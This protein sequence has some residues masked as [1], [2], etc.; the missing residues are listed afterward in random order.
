MAPR[1]RARARAW[2]PVALLPGS[3]ALALQETRGQQADSHRR[4]AERVEQLLSGWDE[5]QRSAEGGRSAWDVFTELRSLGSAGASSPDAVA[6]ISEDPETGVWRK[7]RRAAAPEAP[8]GGGAAPRATAGLVAA[9]APAGEAGVQ[10][11]PTPGMSELEYERFASGILEREISMLSD[12]QKG[13]LEA[14]RNGSITKKEV[15]IVVS[16]FDEH[17]GWMDMYEGLTTSYCKGDIA[18][19]YPQRPNKCASLPNV[20]REGHTFLNHIIQNYDRLADWTVF[21]QAQAPTAGWSGREGDHRNGHIYPGASFHDYVLGG[22]PFGGDGGDNSGGRFVF[23]GHWKPPKV[24]AP[25]WE[26]IHMAFAGNYYSNVGGATARLSSTC[27]PLQGQQSDLDL[28]TPEVMLALLAFIDFLGEGH[29]RKLYSQ[30]A[31]FA[32]SR[33]KIRQRP[34]DF[35]E[36]LRSIVN[37]DVFPMSSVFLELLWYYIPGQPGKGMPCKQDPPIACPVG[38]E[39][40][41]LYHDE[42]VIGRTQLIPGVSMAECAEQCWSE[43]GAFEYNAGEQFCVH[44]DPNASTTDAQSGLW[45][46][47]LTC[48]RV[49][50]R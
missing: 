10:E 39:Q 40:L 34:K 47:T 27:L 20:G 2:L 15:E 19:R 29:E 41:G 22:G 30:G 26:K 21:T 6:G 44:L 35:Y 14:I 46:G 42:T 13:R 36:T 38:F 31:R 3:L 11:L 7:V 12:S 4:T 17:V 25:G 18:L 45:P 23:N 37:R 32:L 24:G 16:H 9:G 28:G 1:P 48:K 33:E 8:A 49:T 43:C 5:S 50:D